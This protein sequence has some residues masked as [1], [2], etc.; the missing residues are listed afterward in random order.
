MQSGDVSSV[1]T[2][3]ITVANPG[4]LISSAVP[5]DVLP[6]SP[7]ITSIDPSTVTVGELS[8]VDECGC[9][10]DAIDAH[11]RSGNE[12]DAVDRQG[13]RTG[14]DNGGGGRQTEDRGR[15]RCTRDR[16][17]EKEEANGNEAPDQTVI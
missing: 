17:I 4:G 5:F 7:Q 3:Q 14:P 12:V 8:A 1:R 10:A 15:G 13:E 9:P 11:L 6:N 16:G 2:L